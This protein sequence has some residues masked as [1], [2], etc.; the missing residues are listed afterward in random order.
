MKPYIPDDHD[1]QSKARLGR[2][3]VVTSYLLLLFWFTLWHLY[4]GPA[5]TA[6]PWVIWL[7]H[8][9]PFLLFA[10]TII[11]G[12]PRGHA[13][14]CFFLL[15][16]FIQAVLSASNPNTASY[17]LGYTLL[18][19]VLFSSAMMYARWQSRYLKQ[20]AHQA[21]QSGADAEDD[22]ATR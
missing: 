1:Y 21:A 18:I 12:N 7:V 20:Q 11:N 10:P 15:L 6:N 16:F 13:W 14:F 4:L 3:V 5:P 2:V 17:G 9:V 19:S 22:L 8:M